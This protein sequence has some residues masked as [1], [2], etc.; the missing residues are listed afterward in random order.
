[1]VAAAGAGKVQLVKRLHEQGCPWN[2]SAIM[3]ALSHNRPEILDFL[4]RQRGVPKS[5]KFSLAAAHS[6]AQCQFT[7]LQFQM[8]SMVKQTPPEIW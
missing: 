1:M 5:S 3:S 7:V 2:E 6:G 4:L 8:Y